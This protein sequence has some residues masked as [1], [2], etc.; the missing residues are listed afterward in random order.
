MSQAT[1][2]P[3]A[4]SR[5]QLLLVFVLFAAPFFAAVMLRFSGWQPGSTRNL[6][7]LIQP[8]IEVADVDPDWRNSERRWHGVSVGDDCSGP[9]LTAEAD[10]LLRVRATLGRHAPRLLWQWQCPAQPALSGAASIAVIPVLTGQAPWPE[11]AA[12]AD[13][14]SSDPAETDETLAVAP[15]QRD[16][17]MVDP[18]GYIVLAWP[19]GSAV[20]DVRRDLSRLI[21]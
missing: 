16:L 18:H 2:A 17:Y 19:A 10:R 8:P 5:L 1:P 3:A 7:Q 15:L 13:R 11:L 4:R 12:P 9:A 20:S 6:G 21:K 14:P